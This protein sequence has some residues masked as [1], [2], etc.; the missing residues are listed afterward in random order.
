MSER[1]IGTVL[2]APHR[3]RSGISNHQLIFPDITF[4]CSG[5]I[6]E[7]VVGGYARRDRP[8]NAH[9]QIWSP[10]GNG[11]YTIK[12]TSEL[13]ATR[14]I[15]SNVF[16]QDVS[17]PLPF[18]PGDVIGAF[19]PW[20][21]DS[22]VQL[23]LD[24]DQDSL[25]YTYSTYNEGYISP[26]YVQ[27]SISNATTSTGA[28]LVSVEIGE[29]ESPFPH[30]HHCSTHVFSA[31]SMQPLWQKHAHHMLWCL[32]TIYFP[33]TARQTLA[34]AAGQTLA[35]AAGLI[36]A[37]ADKHLN[38]P[39]TVSLTSAPATVSL[40]VAPQPHQ[41]TTSSPA[42]PQTMPSQTPL[43]T[44]V[45]GIKP[46]TRLLESTDFLP[47]QTSTQ[48]PSLPVSTTVGL[49]PAT[50]EISSKIDAKI[51]I[52]TAL[53]VTLLIVIAVFVVLTAIM[54][55][56]QRRRQVK[57]ATNSLAVPA[58]AAPN[59]DTEETEQH[60]TETDS[61]YRSTANTES[62]TYYSMPLAGG[63]DEEGIEYVGNDA[64]G[65]LGVAAVIHRVGLGIGNF[66]NDDVEMHTYDYIDR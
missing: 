44:T 50:T 65:Y 60:Y 36:S 42:D 7:W 57:L 24:P 47:S 1:Q 6:V 25:F 15:R 10:Q 46:V 3:R 28:L 19:H 55:L 26:Q 21:N 8:Y 17:P 9:L 61:S 48:P 32:A 66:R 37:T 58:A 54:L 59:R 20:F 41:T 30:K 18:E 27:F 43:K 40:T 35:T 23:D 62:S 22:R 13:S 56:R 63:V 4:D 51:Y 49:P 33:F 16:V 52:I 12:H 45:S 11:L 38:T 31:Y 53:A 34:T 2:E 39:A 14:M 29:R 5:E 64:Y